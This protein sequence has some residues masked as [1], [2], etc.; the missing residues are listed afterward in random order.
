MFDTE[1]LTSCPIHRA[2]L[3]VIPEDG[4]TRVRVTRAALRARV[5]RALP[6]TG[7]RGAYE[8]EW[9]KKGDH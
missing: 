7:H 5:R 2:L 1:S 3:V 9:E 6:V 4:V 8:Q